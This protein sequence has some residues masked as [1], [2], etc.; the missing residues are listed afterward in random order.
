M[1]FIFIYRPKLKCTT[2]WL[3]VRLSTIRPRL[4]QGCVAWDI[5]SPE[6]RNLQEA[7]ATQ[8]RD[9]TRDLSQKAEKQNI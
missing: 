2:F 4:P 1:S 5:V 3:W 7:I 9:Q 8:P 6:P